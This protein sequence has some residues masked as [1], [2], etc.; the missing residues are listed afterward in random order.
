MPASYQLLGGGRLRG[1]GP[2]EDEREEGQDE[3]HEGAEDQEGDAVPGVLGEDAAKCKADA[4]TDVGNRHEDG[5]HGGGYGGLDVLHGE[6]EVDGL[7]GAVDE[8]EEDGSSERQREPVDG[9]KE[10]HSSRDPDDGHPEG[11][12]VAGAV[13]EE[14]AGD[15]T[16]DT[17]DAP[18]R[19]DEPGCAQADLEA[20]GEGGI[21]DLVGAD[22]DEE[23]DEPDA[24][25]APYAR[26]LEGGEGLPVEAADGGAGDLFD[27]EEEGEG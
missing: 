8:A 24:G 25:C 20:V 11:G 10:D 1:T 19:G 17:T 18:E 26:L 13:H 23:D 14:A 2:G 7:R 4:L 27:E 12:F 9:S 3:E 15:G 5:V 6:G 22:D 16:R 21:D